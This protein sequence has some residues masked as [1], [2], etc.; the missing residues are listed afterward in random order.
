MSSKCCLCVSIFLSM[1]WGLFSSWL[2]VEHKELTL[3]MS[4]MLLDFAQE[5]LGET[6]HLHLCA[7]LWD[8]VIF[9][10][11]ILAAS[12][13]CMKIRALWVQCARVWC[14]WHCRYRNRLA[15]VHAGHW[16]VNCKLSPCGW[17]SRLCLWHGQLETTQIV[18][19][20]V[21]TPLPPH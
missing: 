10:L 18:C 5:E 14:A 4:E 3:R 11:P 13:I 9:A 2:Q 6:R 16:Q 12:L 8:H 1:Y 15:G 19:L 7:L 21:N 20:C 17:F